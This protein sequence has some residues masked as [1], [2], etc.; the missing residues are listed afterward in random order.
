MG[1]FYLH[2]SWPNSPKCQLARFC[3]VDVVFFGCHLYCQAFLTTTTAHTIAEKVVELA[4]DVSESKQLQKWEFSR[5]LPGR[6]RVVLW[7]WWAQSLVLLLYKV[8][9]TSMDT[10]HQMQ[11][12]QKAR[13]GVHADSMS[14][15]SAPMSPILNGAVQND[16]LS[17][18][19]QGQ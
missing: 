9:K 15:R 2:K 16:E 17:W 1:A 19:D 13:K 11:H 18:L 12:F 8:G 7:P 10:T 14:S 5:L 6:K 4:R 3:N